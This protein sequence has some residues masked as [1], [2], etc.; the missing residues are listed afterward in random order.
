MLPQPVHQAMDI[1]VVVNNR[2]EVVVLC[3]TLRSEEVSVPASRLLLSGGLSTFLCG[4]LDR[5][6]MSDT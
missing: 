2:P 4:A 1:A 6:S 5:P 3:L